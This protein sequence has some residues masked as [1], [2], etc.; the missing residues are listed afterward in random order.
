M[1][2]TTIS[3]FVIW[4]KHVHDGA[5]I[6]QRILDLQAGET[7]NLTVD[8]MPGT[9]RKMD[10]GKDGRPTRGIRPLG[11]TQDV[12]RSWFSARRGELVNLELTAGGAGAPRAP[13]LLSRPLA[14]SD[15]ER[16]AALEALLDAGNQGWRSEGPYGSRDELHE[17]P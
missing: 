13:H 9:W 14:R 2:T 10:D 5:D 8:G 12:W 1:A 11:R 7:I 15:H 3:D 6:T 16:A 4:I 17:R